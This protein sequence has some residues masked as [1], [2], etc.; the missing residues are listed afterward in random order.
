MCFF[1]YMY[2]NDHFPH[3]VRYT[4]THAVTHN[5]HAETLISTFASR[6]T[7]ILISQ[8]TCSKTSL[9]IHIATYPKTHTC[10]K[11]SQTPIHIK[12]CHTNSKHTLTAD[13]MHQP[14]LSILLSSLSQLCRHRLHSFCNDNCSMSIQIVNNIVLVVMTPP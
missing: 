10:S 12:I 8:N 1:L 6:P 11:M 3:A 2:S 5:T 7:H 14:S 9:G 13:H 4:Q